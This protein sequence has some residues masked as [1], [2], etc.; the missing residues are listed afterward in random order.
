MRDVWDPGL[1]GR[2]GYV[3]RM[4][5]GLVDLLD[6]RPGERVLDVGCGTG[7]LTKAI[8]DRG[9]RVL[10]LDAS[11][12]MI[13]D[14][15][16]RHPGL[17]FLEGDARSMS[18]GAPFDAVFSNAA[19]HWIRPPEAAAARV[20]EALRP[21]GRFVAEFGGEGNVRRVLAAAEV[22]G[23]ALGVE[24][25]D[26][27]HANYFPDVEAYSAVLR[28][29]GFEVGAAELYDRWT[30]LEGPEGLRAWMRMFR[31]AALDR[32]PE[33][34]FFERMEELARPELFVGGVW[35][36]DYRRIRCAARRPAGPGPGGPAGGR[37]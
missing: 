29:A 4:A 17:D 30:P 31:P 8:A 1:Y 34:S 5:A 20:F 32:I 21:G 19:L 9:A 33:E 25:G 2:H 14:A 6:P 27:L 7:E 13:A 16:R 26:V 24:L 28:G 12:A 15:R 36:A 18:F 23:R 3:H 10:G 22:A 35:H 37:A 11:P